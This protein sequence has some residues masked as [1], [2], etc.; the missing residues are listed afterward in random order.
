MGSNWEILDL[1]TWS[2]FEVFTSN[3][4]LKCL[5]TTAKLGALEQRWAAHLPLFDFTI[6]YRSG[7]SNAN[8]DALSRQP[9]G[10]M[11]DKTE[12]SKEDEL[13]HVESIVTM[14]TPVPPD[15]SHAIVTTPI[16]IEVRRMAI[17]EPD[18][19]LSTTTPSSDED[20]S[21]L[22]MIQWLLQHRFS[23]TRRK[24]LA[25]CKR[26]TLQLRN[27]WSFGRKAWNLP[28]G[29]GKN[30]LTSV[31]P[32]Y[33]SGTD[34]QNCTGS[35]TWRTD[36][37]SVT[38]HSE[39]QSHYQPAWWYRT[40]G[41]RE[42]PSNDS[43]TMLLAQDVLRHRELDQE[44]WTIYS[45]K[46]AKPQSPTTHGKPVGNQATWNLSNGLYSPWTSNG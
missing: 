39:R 35:Q 42:K 10:P 18:H 19:N 7:R 37:T 12:E 1:P 8:A 28:L 44:M 24:N 43:R 27:F 33:N 6:N 4:P 30:F 32:C 16:P 31:S 29:R 23:L 45:R 11:P 34:V 20:K 5:Q 2:K 36:T 41:I 25:T 38:S 26:Q 46:D 15:P 14:A 9:R 17:H 21:Y 3:N 22:K 40:S 13:S